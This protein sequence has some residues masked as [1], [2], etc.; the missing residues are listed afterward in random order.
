MT[1]TIL[2]GARILT[3]DPARPRAA[4]LAIRDGRILAL[5][6]T[7]EIRTLACPRARVIDAGGRLVLPGLTDAHVHLLDGGTGLVLSADLGAARSV[8]DLVTLLRAHA[9]TRAGALVTGMRWEPA[10]FGDHNLTRDLIDRAVPD[11]PCILFDTSFHK[12]CVNSAAIAMAGLTE[13]TPDPPNGHIVRDAAG[14]PT[15][16]L[17][18]AATA[19]MQARLPGPGPEDDM[20][21]LRAGQAH[22]NRHGIT[23]IVDP[24]VLARHAA[25]YGA[26]AA[27]DALTLRVSGAAGISP[28]DS[29]AGA[30]ARLQDQRAA[31]RGLFQVN[32]AKFFL[33]GVFENRTAAMIAPYADATGG[34]A[35]L[36]FPPAQI[37]ALFT[38]LDAARFQIH[39]HAIGDMATR[40]ALDGLAA[41]RAANGAWPGLHQLA[42]LQV[43]DPADIP[44]IAS[45]G[46]MANI[47]P[48][49]AQTDPDLPDPALPLIGPARR[50]FTYAFG[51]MRDAGVRLCLSS[52]FSVSTLNPFEI[53]ETALT[54][55]PR[56]RRAPAFLPAE[57]L[58][59]AEALCG[60]TTEAAAAAWR[61]HEAG[62]LRPGLSADVIVL[63]RDFTAGPPE[64]IGDTKVLLTLFRGAEVWRDPAFGG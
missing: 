7:A 21:G 4:A 15:G 28:G 43:I 52:D 16:M 3:M 27:A 35:P 58:R 9:A 33:D 60:Y 36:M 5:G 12:A 44:R 30:L 17:H 20:A 42:H 57:R 41:A 29:A 63:D 46:A 47:Q 51:R 55:A 31:H 34:N 37:A 39:V 49:W 38:A 59:L 48:L 40:A 64:A 8:D 13:A 62:M 50:P 6:A 14:R 11:R 53:I 23:G 25:A 24:H 56:G 10:L 45:L 18:E 2:T 26:A 61:G 1:D 54:R 22:A 19:W 32:A